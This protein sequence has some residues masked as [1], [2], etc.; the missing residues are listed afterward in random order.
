MWAFSEVLAFYEGK[1][2]IKIE[3]LCSLVARSYLKIVLTLYNI[4]NRYIDNLNDARCYTPFVTSK[5]C[6]Y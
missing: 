5:T 3:I 6:Y 4:Y 1:I 2:L